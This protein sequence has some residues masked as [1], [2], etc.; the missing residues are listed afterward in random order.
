VRDPWSDGLVAVQ[1]TPGSAAPDVSV[2]VPVMSPVVWANARLPVAAP[3][4]AIASSG[5]KYLVNRLR[6]RPPLLLKRGLT[7]P[8]GS[9]RWLK[10]RSRRTT[11]SV[12]ESNQIANRTR[13][14]ANS[15]CLYL[16]G[17]EDFGVPDQTVSDSPFGIS[18]R[19]FG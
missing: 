8:K 2:T 18:V 5:K 15:K 9:N 6:E 1:L 19:K 10:T 3:T 7:H 4:T 11:R 14:A 16:R 17:Q 12:R 13:V